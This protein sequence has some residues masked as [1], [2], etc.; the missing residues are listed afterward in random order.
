[1][2]EVAV[3]TGLNLPLYRWPAV[4]SLTG[5]DLSPGMLQQAAR[6]VASDAVPGTRLVGANGGGGGGSSARGGRGGVPVRLVQGDAARLPFPAATFDCVVDTF[7]LCV[8]EAPA[9]A[10][11]ELARVLRPGGRL[12]LLEH[13][14]S[15]N[16][17]L[18][19]YQ[20]CGF[21]ALRRGRCVR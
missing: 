10:L 16:A 20:V 7:S 2:L 12:L 9:A 19:V 13:T 6:R 3:G 15:D 18:G 17:L 11:A 4:T 8:F 1:V 14:R 21:G 5:V